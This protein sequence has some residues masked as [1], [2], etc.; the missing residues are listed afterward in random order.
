[1]GKVHSAGKGRRPPDL[2]AFGLK[3]SFPTSSVETL[4]AASGRYSAKPC[5]TGRSTPV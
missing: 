1:M 5:G 2:S 4:V 3:A